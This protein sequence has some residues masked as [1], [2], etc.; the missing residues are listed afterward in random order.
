MDYYVDIGFG[1]PANSHTILRPR[2]GVVVFRAA[3]RQCYFTCLAQVLGILTRITFPCIWK[4]FIN[5]GLLR[6]KALIRLPLP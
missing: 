2:M 4:P 1:S 5:S 6:R 3:L